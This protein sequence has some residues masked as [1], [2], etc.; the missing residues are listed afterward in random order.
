MASGYTQVAIQMKEKYFLAVVSNIE[1][2]P[3]IFLLPD[4]A[5]CLKATKRIYRP[6][7]INWTVSAGEISKVIKI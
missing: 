5:H 6:V 1:E 2:E 7:Q 4:P 3:E